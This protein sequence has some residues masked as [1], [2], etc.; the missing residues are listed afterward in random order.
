MCKPRI[1]A[2]AQVRLRR[3]STNNYAIVSSSTIITGTIITAT[4]NY[5]NYNNINEDKSKK[6]N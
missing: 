4:H 2:R 6:N 1:S 3:F 5:N